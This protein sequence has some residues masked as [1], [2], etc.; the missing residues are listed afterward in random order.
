MSPK[1]GSTPRLTISRNVT[2]TL[3][4][5]DRAGS[6]ERGEEDTVCG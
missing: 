4:Y 3:T 2:L 1:W 5:L 6:E